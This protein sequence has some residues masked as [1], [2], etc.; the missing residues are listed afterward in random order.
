MKKSNGEDPAKIYGTKTVNNLRI[1]LINGMFKVITPDGRWIE[2]FRKQSDAV[3]CAEG[4][5][6]YTKRRD[7]L[8]PDE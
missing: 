1:K 6:D 3:K 5:K 8:Q 2:E 4:I 7:N